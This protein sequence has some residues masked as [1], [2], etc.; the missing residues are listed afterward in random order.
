MK[1]N[2]K[3]M[4]YGAVSAASGVISYA[5]FKALYSGDARFMLKAASVGML[6]I[7]LGHTAK[8][9]ALSQDVKDFAERMITDHEHF[10]S[11]LRTIGEKKKIKIPENL[12]PKH[13]KI[14]DRLLALSGADFDREYMYATVIDH[15]RYIS[16]FKKALDK[17]KDPEI[18]AWA[19]RTLPVLEQH[20]KTAKEIAPK[21]GVDLTRV[22][23]EAA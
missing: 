12:L 2:T 21:A 15:I 1:K 6:E 10:E 4:F 23:K 13:R 3:L 8:R 18:K 7:D 11:E 14:L 22:E 19:N 5:V 20:L 17:I 16:N 9:N